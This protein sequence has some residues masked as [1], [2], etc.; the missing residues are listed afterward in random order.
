MPVDDGATAQNESQRL[1]VMQR[2]IFDALQAERA[3]TRT[4]ARRFAV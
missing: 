2:E 1:D 4:R 3:F